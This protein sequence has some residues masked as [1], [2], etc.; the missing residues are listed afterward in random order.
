MFL[1]IAISIRDKGIKTHTHTRIYICSKINKF[2]TFP[3]IFQSFFQ[4][5]INDNFFIIFLAKSL[6]I[7]KI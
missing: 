6:Q 5:V 4:K 7:K 3:N 1:G 2:L